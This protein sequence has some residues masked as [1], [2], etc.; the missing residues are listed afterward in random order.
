VIGPLLGGEL[1][2]IG[3]WRLIFLINI[4]FVIVC[5][6]LI[7]VRDPARGAARSRRTAGGHPWRP[8]RRRRPRRVRGSR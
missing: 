8:A 5:T 2:A 3:S 7:M 4:P 6:T 1:L